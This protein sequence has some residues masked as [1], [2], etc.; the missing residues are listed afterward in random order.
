MM[1]SGKRLLSIFLALVMLLTVLSPVSVLA[2]APEGPVNTELT[3]DEPSVDLPGESAL[4]DQEPVQGG[5]PGENNTLQEPEQAEDVPSGDDL[6]VLSETS[7]APVAINDYSTFLAALKVLE[8]YAQTYAREHAGEDATGLVINYIRCGVEKYTS[9]SWVMLAGEEKTEFT[10][11]VSDQ[12]AAN[13]TTA[14]ALRSLTEFTLPNGDK[15]DFVHMFG[16]MDISYHTM[17]TNASAAVTNAD[18]GGWGGDIC[19]L[20]DYTKKYS[21]ITSTTVEDM[22]YELRTDGKHLGYDDPSEDDDVH[23]FGILDLYG[24]LDA[25]YLVQN[26]T[27]GKTISAV[28]SSYFNSNL[29]D[30]FR[31]KFLLRNRF[32]GVGTKEEIRSAVLSAYKSN[33]AIAALE[34]SRGLT[35]IDDLRTACCYAFADY[36]YELTGGITDKPSNDYYTVYSSETSTLAPGVT[37]TLRSATAKD[38]KTLVYYIATADVTRSDVSI[39][40]NYKDNVGTPW[41]MARVQDQMDSAKARHSAPEKPDLYIPNYTPVVGVNADFYNMTNGAPSGALVMEGVEYHGAGSENFFA[42]LKDGTPII[43]APSDYATYK[44]DIAEA[45]GGSI[46]LVKDGQLVVS[47]GGNY[48]DTRASRTCVGITADNRVVLMVMDGRQE[49][50]SAGG[51]AIEIAQV[52]LDAGCVVAMNLDGGG[53]T[54]FVAKEEGADVLSVVNR[55]SDGYARSVS[56][57]LMVVSTAKPSNEFDHAIVSADYDYLTVGTSLPIT[58]SGVSA[59]G[60]AAELPEGT[61]LQ[62]TDSSIGAVSDGTFTATAVGDVQ[63][64]AVADGKVLGSKTLHVVV[65]TALKFGKESVSAIYGVP[66]ELPLTAVY[67]GNQVAVNTSDV[68]LGFV[69]NGQ[70]V[71]ASKA[72]KISGLTFTGDE[73][74]GIRSVIIG[75]ALMKNGQPDFNS[76]VTLTVYLY[77]EGEASFDFDDVTGGD[78]LLAWNR[79]VSNSSTRGDNIYYIDKP[80]VSVDTSYTFAVDMKQIPIPE[81]IKPLMALLPGGDDSSATAWDFLLQLAERVS[82]HTEVKIQLQAPKGVTLD[83]TDMKLVN[84]YFDL[85]SYDVDAAT[86]TLTL[87]CN[88]KN[89]TQAIDPS[90]ANSLCILSGLKLIPTDKADWQSDRLTI[91]VNGKLSYNIYLRS[92]AVYGIASNKDNQEKYGIYPYESDKYTYNGAAEKGAH[93]YEDNLRSFED[94]YTLDKSVKQGWVQDGGKWFYYQNNEAL[95]GI[96]ELPSNVTGESGKFFYDLGD[97]GASKGKISGLFTLNGKLYFAEN[98]TRITK[99]KAISHPGGQVENYFFSTWDYAALN[100]EQTIGGYHYTFKDCVLVRGDLIKRADGNFWYMWAGSWATQQWH[101]IDGNKYYFRSNYNAAKGIYGLNIAGVN[102]YYAFGSD[103]I[104]QEQLTGFFDWDGYTFWV[105]NGIKN[106]YPGLVYFEGYYYYFK[107]NDGSILGPMVK[108]CTFYIEKTNGLMKAAQYTFDEQGRMVNPNPYQ[109]T[110]TWKN[111]NDTVLGT[112][113]VNYGATP[114]YTGATP[115]K[116]SDAQYSY[117]FAG[118][119]PALVPVTGD[120]AYTA[121]YQKVTR[122]YT[123][124]WKNWNG[125]VLQTNKV[126]YGTTPIYTGATPTRPADGNNTYTFSG[127]DKEIAS[128]TGDVTYTAQYTVACSHANTEI[129]GA[130]QATCTESGYTGDTYCKDCNQKLKDGTTIP[131]TGHTEVIDAA[132]AATCTEPGK[133]EGKHCSVCNEVLVAQ[134]VVPAKGHTEEI[135]NA[136]DATLTEDGYTGDTYCSVCNELLKQGETIPKGGVMVKWVDG[137]GKVLVETAVKK[138]DTPPEYAGDTP[139]KNETPY[140]SYEF[141]G[142]DPELAPVNE[143]TTYTAKFKEIGKNGLCID[144]DDTYWLDNGEI[145]LDKG[146]TQVQDENGHNLYYYFGEDGKAVKNVPEGG[147]DFWVEKTHDLLPRWG[148]YFD[149][150]GVIL[151]DEK[152]QKGITDVDGKLYY[153]IDG[154]RV[155]MGMFRIGQDYY[156]AKSNG[157]LIV[158]GSYYCERVNEL[159]PVGTYTFDAEGKMVMPDVTKNG[160]VPEDGSLYYYVKGERNYAGLIKIGDSYYYVRTSGEVVHGCKYWITKTNGLMAEKSYEFDADGKMVMPGAPKNGIVEEDGSLYYYIDGNRTYAGLIEIGGS[161]YYVK[162]TGEVVHDRSYWVTKTNGLMGERSY[163]FGPDGQMLDPQ[164]KDETK[165]GIVAEDGSLYYYEGG[166]RTYA[167]LI[168]IDGSYYYVKTSGEVVHGRK[169]WISKTNGLLSE[170]SYEFDADGK[171]MP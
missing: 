98:G 50:V 163:Q 60:N 14:G 37:Q 106:T 34:T 143:D 5:G 49:P 136:K 112:A 155:H 6:A 111:W 108:N 21:P 159:M 12:D 28:M 146:L 107:Y 41:G 27:G 62:V 35:D 99:W 10:K 132:V 77:K 72:G 67:N 25:Y 119:N 59:S 139:T 73:S 82:Q 2:V 170:K 152:F 15:V 140:F 69:E 68:M 120:T 113:K 100:G 61:T 83:T 161:Y 13:G 129:R 65:P 116:A 78:R 147:Q 166:V 26:L 97:D 137:N 169:Y 134:K 43:G 126:E 91:T 94:T 64:Q 131:A 150:N 24:D 171:M 127:W 105:E 71:L 57:S 36:L 115:T 144:G 86:N 165:S 149:E 80:D 87:V 66:V 11:Y 142:W 128:V 42:I 95:T 9:G 39:Y 90:T 46:M 84:E 123:V 92:S 31:A 29:T 54:T 89:Q 156:Y 104:W 125:E 18:L 8:G 103:G 79:E 20:I 55:P 164:I 32:S 74:S 96:Q 17:Q 75:A 117:T 4:P 158:N 157:E 85:T 56:S 44:N 47:G 7:A 162:S 101:T 102:V 38:G 81:K 63:V 33:T 93:F 23:S 135:R 167:G 124:T 1:R 76:A 153:Y 52:M 40:A 130:K 114:D 122:S 45:V 109:G 141:T 58:V 16:C 154:I 148:Y 118:W 168:Q 160:I 19:D 70:A 151:H 133:T 145:V 110:I 121:Q 138:G 48:Y 30:K 53:S 22:A 3:Q 51:S 88:F